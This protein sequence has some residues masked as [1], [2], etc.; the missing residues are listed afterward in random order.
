M[1]NKT[2]NTRIQLKNASLSDW[3]GSNLKLLAGEIALAAVN[4]TR[5]DGQGGYINVPTYLMKVGDGQKTFSQLN[6]LAAPASDVHEWA[7][8][9]TLQYADLPATL[10]TEIDNLQAA[11]G[12][13][14]SVDTKINAAISALK[15]ACTVADTAV[16]KQF[17]TAVAQEDGKIAVTRRALT[18]DDIPALAISKIT[19]LQGALDL[20]ATVAEVQTLREK[21]Q[22]TDGTGGL[23]KAIADEETARKAADKTLTDAVELINKTTIPN[24]QKSLTTEINN[25]KSA[26]S[27]ADGKAVQAQEEVDALEIVVG[28][29][30]TTV[31]NNKS[32]AETA[33]S[34]EAS[35][36][37]AEDKKLSDAIAQLKTDIGNLENVMN[38]RGAFS[39]KSGCTNPVKGD[40]IVVTAG[41]DAGKE[42]VYDGSAWVEFGNVDAQQT[43]IS[44]LQSRMTTAESDIDNLESTRATKTELAAE[45]KTLNDA[46]ALKADNT[47]LTSTNN[48]VT[49]LE[50]SV[51]TS[52][53]AGLR[54]K[55][56]DLESSVGTSDAAGLRK[57]VIDLETAS[58]TH[59]TKS[60]L[61][62]VEST[63]TKS[64]SDEETAR[65]NADSALQGKIDTINNTTIPGI[66]TRL[67]TAEGDIDKLEAAVN[68]INNTTI[69]TLAT[70]AALNDAKAR[71][72]KIEDDYL[73]AAD[74][75]IINCGNHTSNTWEF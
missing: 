40:V 51:G 34:N 2:L 39:A 19:G 13:G 47:A 74:Q 32:A 16:T 31:A 64:I 5:P 56:K 50:T 52:D 58:A 15:E 33:V 61:E 4:T 6:W 53:S 70:N 18:A 8:K 37:Q 14:G 65:K 11:V 20:K 36:R 28:N 41:D 48:R 60:A 30:A 59:A 57:R 12:T 35:T 3:N 73:M 55:V 10:Q 1:A 43:A 49:A 68:T 23:V 44:N 42:F 54:K 27:T 71:I 45:V 69:P 46:I 22:G 25:A 75:F 17:V 67:T 63:L 66:T 9:E 29:L 24:L 21:V 62:T 38:F 26:A 72:K 7:K